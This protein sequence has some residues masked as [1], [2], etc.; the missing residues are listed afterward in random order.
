MQTSFER[1]M[2]SQKKNLR[3]QAIEQAESMLMSLTNQENV[4][5]NKYV[6]KIRGAKA[7]KSA[8]PTVREQPVEEDVALQRQHAEQEALLDRLHEEQP[9]PE[10]VVTLHPSRKSSARRPR[11]SRGSSAGARSPMARPSPVKQPIEVE[12]HHQRSFY[13]EE[14]NGSRCDSQSAIGFDEDEAA[15]GAECHQE[16]APQKLDYAGF[17]PE[18]DDDSLERA[19]D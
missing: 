18:Y 13:C 11:K 6:N 9:S 4:F 1:I 16:P 7:S 14:I 8:T 19:S 10:R 15:A 17:Q 3:R 2:D 12:H 5:A